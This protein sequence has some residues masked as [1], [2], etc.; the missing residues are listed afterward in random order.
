MADE[1]DLSAIP[2]RV[3]ALRQ[4]RV[5]E[6]GGHKFIRVFFK[7]PTFCAHCKKMIWGLYNQGYRCQSC[8]MAIH[9]LCHDQVTFACPGERSN[10]E[11]AAQMLKY[12]HNFD[13]KSYKSPTFCDLCGS[14]LYGLIRQ[15]L[16]CKDC[17]A[18]CHKKCRENFPQLCQKGIAEKYG[19]IYLV[20]SLEVVS[21]KLSTVNVH[22]IEAKNLPNRLANPYVVL[23]LRPD[24]QKRQRQKSQVHT[25]TRNPKFNETFQLYCEQ[26]ELE[27]T[28]FFVEVQIWDQDLISKTLMGMVSFNCEELRKQPEMKLC[29]WFKLDKAKHASQHSVLITPLPSSA[30]LD[31][32][33]DSMSSASKGSVFSFSYLPSPAPSGDADNAVDDDDDEDDDVDFVRKVTAPFR[34]ENFPTGDPSYT[35]ED[36]N[37]LK[38]LGRGGYGKVLLAELKETKVQFAL[39]AMKKHEIYLQ[40]GMDYLLAERQVFE[41][42]SGNPFIT[43]LFASFQTETYA[44]FILEFIPGGDLFNHCLKHR[45]VFLHEQNV[46]F[47]AAEICEALWY[48]HSKHIIYRDLKMDN[49]LLSS[50]G[51]LKLT[52][53]GICKL[54][55]DAKNAYTICG[56]PNYMAPEIISVLPYTCSVDFWSLGV[57]IF[58]MLTGKT[59]FRGQDPE[60]VQQSICSQNIIIPKKLSKEASAAI[61]AFL[62]RDPS[63][64]LGAGDSG[65]SKI[66]GHAF[67]RSLNWKKLA[68]K[69]LPPPYIPTDQGYSASNFDDEFS[70]APPVLTPAGPKDHVDHQEFSGFTFINKAYTINQGGRILFKKRDSSDVRLSADMSAAEPISSVIS[71]QSDVPFDQPEEVDSLAVESNAQHDQNAKPDTSVP[72]R[73]RRKITT[74]RIIRAPRTAEPN[75]PMQSDETK[76]EAST[77]SA[78]SEAQEVVDAEH[79]EPK[80]V[81]IGLEGE[82][83]VDAV[84]DKEDDS[85]EIASASFSSTSRPQSEG[86]LLQS[87]ENLSAITA[88][89][90]CIEDQADNDS[91]LLEVSRIK[92]RMGPSHVVSHVEQNGTHS[93]ECQVA[94]DTHVAPSTVADDVKHA[95][96]I[97]DCAEHGTKPPVRELAATS[98]SVAPPTAASDLLLGSEHDVDEVYI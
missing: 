98:V 71:K 15:G 30:R 90:Q 65:Q 63:K 25:R 69:Q 39:K 8:K 2:K 41:I 61:L 14:L 56:T 13:V 55:G 40:D 66:K 75:P 4:A 96:P 83:K 86:S 50:S 10:A 21:P 91:C 47:Y 94:S 17:G 58:E 49:V 73:S 18:N 29:G 85:F 74:T 84:S 67:F 70:T 11:D 20:I 32:L 72:T 59:P 51:H 48:L 89:S 38:V 45:A 68:L 35:L 78:I 1:D 87:G 36:F 6:V 9:K 33:S 88:L 5:H 81:L 79:L 53:F 54:L 64:R 57:I 23:S 16:Q 77:F 27:R 62:N 52:D 93:I 37:L 46:Q 44:F 95:G 43:Q 28:Q 12:P 26:T 7:Q 19:R 42:G 60:E 97:D 76:S 22:V 31:P 34:P 82:S 92:T 24:P 3:Q 80:V